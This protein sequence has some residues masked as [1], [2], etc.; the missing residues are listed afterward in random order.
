MNNQ[1]YMPDLNM[2]MLPGMESQYYNPMNIYN[3]EI[4]MPMNMNEGMIMGNEN[5]N[6]MGN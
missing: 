2:N 3:P 1:M 5:Y 4:P 6:Y